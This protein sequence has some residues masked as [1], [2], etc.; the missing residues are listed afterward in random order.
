MNQ[1]SAHCTNRTVHD[2]ESHIAEYDGWIE[3]YASEY[4]RD[5]LDEPFFEVESIPQLKPRVVQARNRLAG[6]NPEITEH[7]KADLF[8]SSSPVSPASL[9]LTAVIPNDSG[10]EARIISAQCMPHDMIHDRLQNNMSE[11]SRTGLIG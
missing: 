9:L 5:N 11:S 1:Q 2:A 8:S 6:K 3:G 4:V 10:F 7:L